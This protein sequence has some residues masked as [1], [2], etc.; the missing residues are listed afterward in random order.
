[1]AV[2]AVGGPRVAMVRSPC[3]IGATPRAW[4]LEGGGPKQRRHPSGGRTVEPFDGA[5]NL[6]PER[7]PG[8]EAARVDYRSLYDMVRVAGTMGRLGNEATWC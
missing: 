8:Y 2:L 6:R 7:V 5:R 4:V 3:R 1:M